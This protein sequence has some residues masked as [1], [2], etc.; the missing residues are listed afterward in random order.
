VYVVTDFGLVQTLDPTTLALAKLTL[1]YCANAL[2][3]FTSPFAVTFDARGWF[4]DQQTGG[5]PN[6]WLL[7]PLAPTDAGCP[8]QRFQRAESADVITGITY[9]SAA[10]GAADEKL[11]VVTSPD[12]KTSTLST[13]S[14][15]SGYTTPVGPLPGTMWLAGTGDGH[16]LGV[17]NPA[18]TVSS[19]PYGVFTIDPTS[20]ATRAIGTVPGTGPVAFARGQ[21]FVFASAPG[22][23]RGTTDLYVFDPSS[24][25]ATKRAHFDFVT[26]GA[27]A[28]SCAAP[29][30]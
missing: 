22:G 7:L 27:G 17:Q 1:P 5:R 20:A 26:G 28:S 24:Q 4:V 11:Y 18:G 16:L 13:L 25:T 19:G 6:P 14:T 23:A 12:L 30:G 29:K 3:G 10:P 9:V 8:N 15:T 2:I 21:L